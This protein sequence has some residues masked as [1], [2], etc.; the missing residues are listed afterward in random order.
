MKMGARGRRGERVR[1]RSPCSKTLSGDHM[2]DS[3]GEAATA[4]KNIVARTDSPAS[5]VEER[6]QA[7]LRSWPTVPVP[8]SARGIMA[9]GED[10]AGTSQ[11][12]R[13]KAVCANA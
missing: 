9:L 2:K 5:V 1:V 6:L 3:R 8:V 12:R 4:K 7:A 13:R 11:V 10:D